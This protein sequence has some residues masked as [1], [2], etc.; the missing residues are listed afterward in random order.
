MK[1]RAYAVAAIL[2]SIAATVPRAHAA[3]V[4]TKTAL[5]PVLAVASPPRDPGMAVGLAGSWAGDVALLGDSDRAFRTGLFSF[6]V[7]HLGYTAALARRSSP[8]SRRLVV[9]I[10]AA[11]A[12]GAFAFARA[13][14]PS[15]G[16]PVG[17]YALTLGTMVAAASTARGAGARRVFGGA[18]LFAVS[19]ALLGASRF[20][21]S[22][23]AARVAS[24]GVMPT[25]AAAQWLIHTGS[26]GARHPAG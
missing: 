10:V 24:A 23:R 17:L 11:S 20:V 9:P 25:Y 6:L 3:R 21:L 8:G 1:Q 5:M 2:D 14:G 15:M 7:A 13:A 18:A 22:G 4:V 16:K 26:H 19:D 12:A